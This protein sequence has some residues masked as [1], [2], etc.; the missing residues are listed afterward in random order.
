MLL[1]RNL[2]RSAAAGIRHEAVGLM[3][4]NGLLAQA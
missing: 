2:L 4:A 1:D 3:R